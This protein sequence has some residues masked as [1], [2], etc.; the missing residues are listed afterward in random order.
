MILIILQQNILEKVMDFVIT[1]K[2]LQIT[3]VTQ[4]Q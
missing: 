1:S 3:M 4:S 2:C